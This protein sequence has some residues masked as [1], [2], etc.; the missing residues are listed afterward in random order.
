MFEVDGSWVAN[1]RINYLF[2]ICVFDPIGPFSSLINW[3]DD[4]PD[5]DVSVAL[6]NTR[7]LKTEIILFTL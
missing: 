2:T 3:S 1:E 4:P 6:S 5:S 7:I